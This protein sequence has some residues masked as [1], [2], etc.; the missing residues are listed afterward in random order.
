MDERLFGRAKEVLLV[1][2]NSG[3]VC[4][5]IPLLLSLLILQRMQGEVGG[6]KCIRLDWNC[7]AVSVS[8]PVLLPGGLADRRGQ[9][10]RRR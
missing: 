8:R 4:A 10:R 6:T 7:L 2:W 5:Y 1:P 3:C 9:W